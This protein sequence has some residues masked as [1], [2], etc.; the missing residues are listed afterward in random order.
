MSGPTGSSSSRHTITEEGDLFEDPLMV[1][2]KK[3]VRVTLL[4]VFLVTLYIVYIL[5]E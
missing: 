4:I 3:W 2:V 5:V 1:V